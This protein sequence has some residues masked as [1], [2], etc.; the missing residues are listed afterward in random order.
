MD[1]HLLTDLCQLA[2][3]DLTEEERAGFL[4]KFESLLHFVETVQAHAETGDGAPLTLIDELVPRRDVPQPFE[5]PAGWNHE[6]RVPKVIDFEG[7]G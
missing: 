3:L 4:S 2:R 6:Y 1:P 5:W 7:A